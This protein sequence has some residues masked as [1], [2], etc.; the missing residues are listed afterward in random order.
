MMPFCVKTA[1]ASFS[2]ED[3][4]EGTLSS[5]G[6]LRGETFSQAMAV[7]YDARIQFVEGE[8]GQPGGSF[9][10]AGHN[11]TILASDRGSVSWAG[12]HLWFEQLRWQGSELQWQRRWKGGRAIWR[13]PVNIGARLAQI[14]QVWQDGGS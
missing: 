5:P 9:C 13:P 12:S 14:A 4:V 11:V 2:I 8:A 7:L 3:P 1:E 10:I 6:F